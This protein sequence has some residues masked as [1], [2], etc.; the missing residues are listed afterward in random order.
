VG[1]GKAYEKN[2]AAS[3]SRWILLN[4]MHQR[5]DI[6]TFAAWGEVILS[7]EPESVEPFEVVRLVEALRSEIQL[8]ERQ[9][10]SAGVP[11]PIYKHHFQKAYQATNI[12][13]IDAPWR[14]FKQYITSELLLCLSFA[15]H[16]IDEDEPK[17]E[18]EQISEIE[19][20]ISELKESLNSADVDIVLKHFVE[21]QIKL[22]ERGIH[23][24]RI[25]GSKALKKCYVDG[26][27]EI[28]EHEETIKDHSDSLVVEKLRKAWNH[29]QTA[30]EK[31]ATMNKSLETWTKLIE[32][33]SDLLDQVST[34]T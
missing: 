6:S 18:E 23:D 11:E 4:A 33:G 21:Q 15:A 27:G 26:L 19:E 24:F 14:T 10:A 12:K 29:V 22:L 13:N 17:L 20:I 7:G 34:L 30:T 16:I 5:D 3:R 1:D 25:R 32:K 8:A 28:V 2:N 31:A 9:L